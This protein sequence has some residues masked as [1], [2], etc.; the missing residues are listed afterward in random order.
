MGE[1]ERERARLSVMGAELCSP[2]T[3]AF[4]TESRLFKAN[5]LGTQG[6][7]H[8]EAQPAG[9]ECKTGRIRPKNEVKW[10]RKL[11]REN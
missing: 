3:A 9:Q 5:N 11:M 4:G 2:C 6:M 7:Q 8:T 10:K 1:R